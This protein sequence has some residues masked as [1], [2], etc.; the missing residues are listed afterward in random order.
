MEQNYKFNTLAIHA[1]QTPDSD[2]HSRAV[3]IY[4][5]TAYTF[6]STEYA[7]DLFSLSK[8]GNIYARLQNPTTDMLEARVA[9]LDGG[10]AAVAFSSGHAA[11]FN[12]IL[13]LANAGDEIVSSICIYGGAI[14]MFGVTLDRLGI[15]VKFVNPDDFEA[16]ENAVTN[17]TRAFF[18]E[19]VGNPNA[20]VA[21]IEK[22]AEIAHRYGIP[23]IV[24]STFTTPYLCRPIEFGADFVI[25]SATKLLGGHGTAMAGIVVDSG[26]FKFE[27]NPRFPQY[28]QPD[29]SY[30]GMI[31]AKAGP[32]AFALRL[33]AILLRDVG[34]CLSPFNAFLILQGIETLAVRIQR[35]CE[36]TLK[37]ARY[38]KKHPDVTFVHA[39]ALEDDPYHDL[40]MKYMPKGAG[41]VFTFGLKGGRDSGGKFIDSLKLISHVAN[42]GDVRSLV[43]HPATT[44]HSQLNE[45][46]L[47]QSGIT[48]ETVRLSIGLED[49]DDIIADL[50]QA[51]AAAVR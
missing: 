36:N 43:V 25:H 12:M 20:N 6:E 18:V 5:T 47:R 26:N 35:H 22:L 32:A 4:Q 50:E 11:M 31:F 9:A 21:D 2:T 45:E 17:K 1:G 19:G 24:D 30:H 29:P 46:Q 51:I 44:T 40:M 28:N 8:P 14:N 48:S 27:G 16:W 41:C 37:V 10:V 34:A 13:N 38:L 23:L 42:V 39:P 7:Q 3:P 33:R 15:K 49:A